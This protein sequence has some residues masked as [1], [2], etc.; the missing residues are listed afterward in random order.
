MQCIIPFENL[1]EPIRYGYKFKLRTT[2]ASSYLKERL[3]YAIN[4]LGKDEW[5][6]LMV[7]LKYT[8]FC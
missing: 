4:V 5:F 7:V 1:Q 2:Y 6:G 8:I 3:L